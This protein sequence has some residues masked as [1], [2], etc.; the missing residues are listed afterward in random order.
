LPSTGETLR[1]FYDAL[2]AAY[3]PQDWWPGETPFEMMVGAVLTQNTNWKN[4]EKA[5]A[6]LKREGLLDPFALH[7]ASPERIAEVIRPAGYYNVKA[8]RLGNLIAALV[9][10]FDGDLERFFAGSVDTLRERLYS[11]SG[12]GLETADSIVLYAAER[13]T[14]VVDA[15]TFRVTARHGL[16]YPEAGY[17]ELKSLFEDNLPAEVALFNEYHALIVKVGKDHCKKRPQCAGCPLEH[18]PHDVEMEEFA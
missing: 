3:G 13:P 4:V 15:Y 8:R 11:I 1:E 5:I 10:G 2:L 14:F 7:A 12:I 9:D 6:N 18:F 17:E 16:I